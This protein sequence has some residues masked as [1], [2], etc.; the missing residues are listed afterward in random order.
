MK[1]ILAILILPVLIVSCTGKE[2]AD[3]VASVNGAPILLR[4][5]K[6]ELKAVERRTPGFVLTGES[7]EDV[8]NT[9]IERKLLIQEAVKLGLSEDEHFIETIKSYWEQ[10]LIRELVNA[11]TRQWR[12]LPSSAADSVSDKEIERHYE[13][14][15]FSITIKTVKTAGE[16]DLEGK[17]DLMRRGKRVSG[18]AL[19][20]PLY[21]ENFSPDDP[22]LSAFDLKR[23]GMTV[24]KDIDGIT[25]VYIAAKEPAKI[26]PLDEIRGRISQYLAEFKKQKAMDDW[27]RGV[28]KISD[29]RIEKDAVDRVRGDYPLQGD[30]PLRRTQ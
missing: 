26:P 15:R 22:L 10:T 7:A 19:E 28:K 12:G 3:T 23:G 29:I 13:R 4:D 25:L 27:L 11:K 18:E 6:K 14:M 30:Y 1:R 21:A 8:L 2:K 20:G 17:K 5:F 24:I 16:K 9:M